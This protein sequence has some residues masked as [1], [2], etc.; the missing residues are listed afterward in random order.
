MGR[1]GLPISLRELCKP[2]F[3]LITTTHQKVIKLPRGIL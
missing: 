2:F 3:L 1:T